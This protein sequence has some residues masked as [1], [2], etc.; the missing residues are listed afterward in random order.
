[1]K[2]VTLIFESIFFV[3]EGGF[4]NSD[5]QNSWDLWWKKKFEFLVLIP[6]PKAIFVLCPLSSYFLVSCFSVVGRSEGNIFAQP[7]ATFVKEL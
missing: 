6:K 7:E 3:Q 4:N 1:M 2:G 5:C